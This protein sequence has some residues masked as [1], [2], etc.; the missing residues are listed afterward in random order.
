MASP[1]T[2]NAKNLE[3]LGAARL[4][5]LLI[6]VTTGSAAAKRRLRLELAGEAGVEA[7]R[8]E[9]AKRLTTIATA[10]SIVTW[11]RVKT[12]AADIEAQHRAIMEQVAPADPSEAL[13]LLW[14]L[15]D[16]GNAVLPRSEDFNGKLL[17]AFETAAADLGRL[18]RDA[19]AKPADL[20]ERAFEAAT[21]DRYE[22][23]RGMIPDLSPALGPEGLEHLRSL[24]DAWRSEPIPGDGIV[25]DSAHAR[26]TPEAAERRRRDRD[27]RFLLQQIADSLGDVDAYAAQFDEE[28]RTVPAVAAEIALRQLE[29]GKAEDALATLDGAPPLGRSAQASQGW[30]EVRIATLEALGRGEEALASRWT[31]FETTLA[32]AELRAYLS[33]LPDFEDF[34]AEQRAL[35]LALQHPEPA[36]AL[37]FLIA[38]PALDKADRLVRTHAGRWNGDSY[39]HLTP[40]ADALDANYPFAA[41][42]L[43]RAMIDFALRAAR[44]K[45]YRHAARHLAECARAAQRIES[46]G[47]L[48]PHEEYVGTLRTV[49]GRKTGFWHE[50]KRE[51]PA[52]FD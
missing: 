29:S 8:G 2:L 34:D 23:L 38:W 16:C 47:D 14:R 48:P 13:A 27:A 50:V 19:N 31:R 42:I 51:L 43:R 49:H 1:K 46:F 25:R 12:V 32:P 15:V 26:F 33:K 17:R 41:T 22:V 30:H 9:I 36:R 35:A 44:S 52:L 10:R 45:R 18:A 28:A 3:A 5:A 4:A 40:A 7:V 37:D 11:G 20:A 6:E 24:V 21:Q 39:E